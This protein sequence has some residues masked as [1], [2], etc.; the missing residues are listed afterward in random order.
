MLSRR[1]HRLRRHTMVS[2]HRFDS[3]PLPSFESSRRR[4]LAARQRYAGEHHAHVHSACCGQIRCQRQRTCDT[5]ESDP[6]MLLSISDIASPLW[7]SDQS[8]RYQCRAPSHRP[9]ML[10]SLVP[11]LYYL[12][13]V[14]LDLSYGTPFHRPL[15]KS[16]HPPANTLAIPPVCN[17]HPP[18]RHIPLHDIDIRTMSVCVQAL[19]NHRHPFKGP[20]AAQSFTIM[21]VLF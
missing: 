15:S 14:M 13:V 9:I 1:P 19:A 16:G 8:S 18:L 21:S 5:A 2:R 6:R 4:S 10:V 17:H 11:V 20:F 3:R 12:D 7:C